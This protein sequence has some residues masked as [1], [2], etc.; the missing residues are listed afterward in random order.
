M[1]VSIYIPNNSVRGFSF[2]HTSLQHLL[3]KGFLMIA[4]PTSLPKEAKEN[5][6]ET[7]RHLWKKS[8]M[9]ETD[10]KY[11][12]FLDQKKEHCENDYTAQSNLQIQC[13]PYHTT[14]AAFIEL[15]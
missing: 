6:K 10:E 9:T 3:F 5:Y 12:V 2:L 15:E 4:I 7:I 14:K 11:I 1:V 13:K 8:K